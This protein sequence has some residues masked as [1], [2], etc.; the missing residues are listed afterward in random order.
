MELVSIGV[1]HS[2]YRTPS[3]APR[4]GRLSSEIMELEIHDNYLTGLDGLETYGHIVVLYWLDRADRTRLKATPPGTKTQRGVFSTRSPHR[5]NPIGMSIAE[6]I[7]I[8]GKCIK[9]RGLDALDRTPIIDI[10]PYSPPIDHI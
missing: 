8:K 6:L 2:P 4:Q 9:V 1:I 5:P 7:E 10:K 3:D